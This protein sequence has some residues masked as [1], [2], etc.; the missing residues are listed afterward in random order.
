MGIGKVEE[1]T[2]LK[3]T[4]GRII[5]TSLSGQKQHRSRPAG[6]SVRM[7]RTDFGKSLALESG[8]DA[9]WFLPLSVTLVVRKTRTSWSITVR[10]IFLA[11]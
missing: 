7:G 6:P 8:G 10:V 5:V 9:M 1:K 3:A 11:S 4:I 2:R